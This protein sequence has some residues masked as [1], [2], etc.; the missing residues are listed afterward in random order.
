[1]D[2]REYEDTRS[3]QEIA[4]DR[5]NLKI[6]KAVGGAIE[7]KLDRMRKIDF[8]SHGIIQMERAFEKKSWKIL[9]ALNVQDWSHEDTINL[10]WGG[11]VHEHPEIRIEDVEAIWDATQFD[12]RMRAFSTLLHIL[13]KAIGAPVDEK[14]Y[15]EAMDMWDKQQAAFKD[16]EESKI[17]E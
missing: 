4:E 9:A 12:D 7:V 17:R 5:R 8:R 2:S 16:D 13:A 1:M 11:M 14:A 15:K 10:I 6:G 3:P